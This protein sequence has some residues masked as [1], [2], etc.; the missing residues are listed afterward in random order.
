MSVLFLLFTIIQG[1][2]QQVVRLRAEQEFAD[3]EREENG[4]NLKKQETFRHFLHFYDI[5]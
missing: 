3:P 4:E 1:G 2:I 5:F